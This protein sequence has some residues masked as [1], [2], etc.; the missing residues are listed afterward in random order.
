MTN[1]K[2]GF[3]FYFDNYPLLSALPMEQRGL[4]FSSLMVYADRVWRDTSVTLEEVMDGFPKLSQEA[5]IACGFMG[6]AIY[7]DTLAWLNKREYRQQNRQRNQAR[8]TDPTE[9]N[10]RGREDMERT[11]KLLEQMKRDI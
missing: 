2:K 6:T 3:I 4:L 1:E 8:G 9:V 11:R 5:R 7:R 10:R